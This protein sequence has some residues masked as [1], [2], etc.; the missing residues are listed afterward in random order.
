MTSKSTLKLEWNYYGGHG[1]DPRAFLDFHVNNQS[2]F[3]LFKERGFDVISCLGW[4][5]ASEQAKAVGRLL[6]RES[7][8]LPGD[9]RSLYI[10]HIDGDIGCGAVTLKIDRADDTITWKSFGFEN[11][12]DKQSLDLDTLS[13]IGP[14]EFESR[15]YESMLHDALDQSR[16]VPRHVAVIGAAGGLGQGIL[17]VCRE[18]GTS[19][20]AIVRSRPE[21]I[22]DVPSGSRVAVVESLDDRRALTEA[23]AGADAVLTALGVTATAQEKSALLSANMAAVEESMLAAGV[24]RIVLINTLLASP[25]GQRASRLM[26]FF[27]WMPGKIGR[28]AREQQAVID[29]LGNGAFASLRWTLVRGGLNSRGKNERPVASATWDGALNSWS[30]VSYDAMGQWMLEEA[31]A[32]QF[33]RAAPLVSRRR[34]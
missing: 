24:D 26:R 23:F 27:M 29:A 20:T 3:R 22:T 1:G 18:A 12:Y 16:P 15:H 9:R 2:L 28:G 33:I 11:N 8:D 7:A 4:G 31:V 6:V 21:R 19:F 5:P 32:N 13:D 30:P 14:F 25:P 10:C 34:K 17:R